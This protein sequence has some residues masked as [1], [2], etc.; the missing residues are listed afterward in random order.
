MASWGRIADLTITGTGTI[1]EDTNIVTGTDTLFTEELEI[2]NLIALDGN[3]FQVM[4]ING[5]EELEVRPLSSEDLEDED[6]TVSEAPKYLAVS[7]LDEIV[8][9][10]EDDIDTAS[11][12]LGIKTPGWT[13]YKE[14]G[15]GR[16]RV[17]TLV[18]MKRT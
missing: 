10:A 14:Y 11:R 4:K 12:A 9:V 16:R 13:L 8:L 7:Q 5:D 2:R 3:V 17:E 15:T 6:I 18:A 1:D